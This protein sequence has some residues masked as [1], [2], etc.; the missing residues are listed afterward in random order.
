MASKSISEPLKGWFRCRNVSHFRPSMVC[1]CIA[2]L[3]SN[4]HGFLGA[5]ISLDHDR[6]Y[7]F[8]YPRPGLYRGKPVVRAKQDNTS[9]HLYISTTACASISKH[10]PGPVEPFPDQ[11]HLHALLVS[12]PGTCENEGIS[13]HTSS[14]TSTEGHITSSSHLRGRQDSARHCQHEMAQRGTRIKS[15]DT[16]AKGYRLSKVGQ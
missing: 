8:C 15:Q 16:T 14:P 2:A 11:G 3:R 4:A 5:A 13:Q 6:T 10:I 1:V 7:A 9:R 12:Q